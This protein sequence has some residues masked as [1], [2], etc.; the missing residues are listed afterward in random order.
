MRPH[1]PPMPTITLPAP[2]QL[3]PGKPPLSLQLRA[4][5][6]TGQTSSPGPGVPGAAS[7]LG[8]IGAF[9]RSAGGGVEDETG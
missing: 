5:T 1:A 9:D 4:H 6:G 3:S 8:A 7:S 2:P